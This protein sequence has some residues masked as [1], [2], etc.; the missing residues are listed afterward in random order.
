MFLVSNKMFWIFI[1]HDAVL[2][3]QHSNSQVFSHVFDHLLR[4]IVIFLLTVYIV[5]DFGKRCQTAQKFAWLL[6]LRGGTPAC[7]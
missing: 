1:I 3:S 6:T 2:L 5:E 7:V 4:H